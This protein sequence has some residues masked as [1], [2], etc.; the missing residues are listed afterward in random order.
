MYDK[1]RDLNYEAL[2]S[3]QSMDVSSVAIRKLKPFQQRSWLRK[4]SKSEIHPFKFYWQLLTPH[5]NSVMIVLYFY[6]SYKPYDIRF[7]TNKILTF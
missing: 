3:S 4:S 2:K 7:Y 6:V 1:M 5:F